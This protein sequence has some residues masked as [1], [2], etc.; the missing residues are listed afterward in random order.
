MDFKYPGPSHCSCRDLSLLVV[1]AFMSRHQFSCRD[2]N[3]SPCWFQLIACGVV[4]SRSCRDIHLSPLQSSAVDPD[5]ATSGCCRD[6]ASCLLQPFTGGHDVATSF[7][8]SRQQL[9]VL[10][11]RTSVSRCRDISLQVATSPYAAVGCTGC[12]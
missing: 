12:L 2:I 1:T 6:I 9:L 10:R 8:L 4:T 3:L 5:V 11:L 7:L